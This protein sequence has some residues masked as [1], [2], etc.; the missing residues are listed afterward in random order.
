MTVHLLPVEVLKRT[1]SINNGCLIWKRPNL[2]AFT[3]RIAGTELLTGY[4]SVI[5]TWNGHR[6]AFLAHRAIWAMTYGEWPT[7]SIDHINRD[8]V[9]NRPENLRL[10]SAAENGRNRAKNKNNSS[11]YKGVTWDA[12]HG[13]W[14]S[15]ITVNR[16]TKYLG[17]FERAEQAHRAYTDASILF[18]GEYGSAA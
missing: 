7:K 3:G 2:V 13:K 9:D 11:G 12:A 18:H 17:L 8:R 4:I 5:F 6:H 16:K 15:S 14:R 10:A 1:F